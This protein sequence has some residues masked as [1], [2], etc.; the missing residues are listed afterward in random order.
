MLEFLLMS[1][2]K[3]VSG[4]VF[5]LFGG[6]IVTSDP[7]AYTDRYTYSTATVTAGTVLRVARFGV[8]ASSSS[9]GGF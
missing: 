7:M 2:Q 3:P 9:P 5:G 8:A 1:R 4:A 6:G